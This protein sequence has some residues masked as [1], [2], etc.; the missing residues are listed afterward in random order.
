M[1]NLIPFT[2]EN[3]SVRMFEEDGKVFFCGKDVATALG[4]VNTKDA[5]A[6]HC[7]GVTKRYPLQ[8]A[9]GVQQVRFITEGDLYRLIAS[10]KLPSAQAFEAKV[11]DEILPTIRKTG[12]Y[13]TPRQLTGREL[14]A[15][16][17]DRIES[18]GRKGK[19]R[20]ASG[21]SQ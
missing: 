17:S 5:L 11:F 21:G 10:S 6:K 18:N 19:E 15:A 8:T 12:S 9:G 7:K 4:Y 1:S 3:T 13:G 20:T 16:A 14:M 2:F